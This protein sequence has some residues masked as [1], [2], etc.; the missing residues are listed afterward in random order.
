MLLISRCFTPVPFA[1]LSVPPACETMVT[2]PA[3]QKHRGDELRAYF[4]DANVIEAMHNIDGALM[5][6]GSCL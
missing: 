4:K 1:H 2:V 5:T 6:A 3:V